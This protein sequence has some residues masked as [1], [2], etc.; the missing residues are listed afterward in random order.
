MENTNINS[1]ENINN[2]MN[3]AEA[4]A[5]AINN[6]FAAAERIEREKMVFVDTRTEHYKGDEPK[7]VRII[8][9]LPLEVLATEHGYELDKPYQR[10]RFAG[11]HGRGYKTIREMGCGTI[12]KLERGHYL[13]RIK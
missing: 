11:N 6:V 2:T 4:M 10:G 7:G 1:M 3:A 9:V 8:E 13:Q 5:E 12:L